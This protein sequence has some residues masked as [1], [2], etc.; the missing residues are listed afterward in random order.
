MKLIS[1]NDFINKIANALLWNG[2]AFY[3]TEHLDIYYKI[4]DEL[5]KFPASFT[6]MP[7]RI[8]EKTVY[9]ITNVTAATT[10]VS[11]ILV[12]KKYIGNYG[13]VREVVGIR[14]GK[15]NNKKYVNYKAEGRKEI[16]EME[17]QKFHLWAKRQLD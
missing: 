15:N 11:D 2:M 13:Y 17:L 8:G 3:E 9:R 14:E 10:G 4:A 1:K 6:T 5:M 12:G 7:V 16:R